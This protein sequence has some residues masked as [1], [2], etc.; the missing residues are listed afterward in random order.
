M[1]GSH[2]KAKY[3][4][5]QLEKK[6][7][8]DRRNRKKARQQSKLT[9]TELEEQLQLVL[10]GETGSLINQLREENAR[11]RAR[12]GQYQCKMEFLALS[13]KEMLDADETFDAG[14]D[15]QLWNEERGPGI[16]ESDSPTRPQVSAFASEC[17]ST[18]SVLCEVFNFCQKAPILPAASERQPA[19]TVPHQQLSEYVMTWKLY[20]GHATP[21]FEILIERFCL[22]KEPIELSK[23]MAESNLEFLVH[24]QLTML[25]KSDAHH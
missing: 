13:C 6:R 7:W 23:G 9:A 20:G 1:E 5:K 24:A 15:W 14:K 2:W 11:L 4:E 12:L 21:G 3:T 8:V 17:L 19:P 25:S 10:H 22:D 18:G 16:R